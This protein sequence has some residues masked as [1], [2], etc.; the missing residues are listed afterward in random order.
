MTVGVFTVPL[1]LIFVFQQLQH[2]Q[3]HFYLIFFWKGASSIHMLDTRGG[4]GPVKI[5]QPNRFGLTHFFSLCNNLKFAWFGYSWSKNRWK[6]KSCFMAD[7]N[8]FPLLET[9][10]MG[11]W[12]KGKK[13]EQEQYCYKTSAG[14]TRKLWFLFTS[15]RSLCRSCPFWFYHFI[16]FRCRCSD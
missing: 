9:I 15:L 2:F 14:A 7:Y 5:A 10:Q 3:F 4:G 11:Q 13:D 6:L 8:S 12:K 1:Y 16:L